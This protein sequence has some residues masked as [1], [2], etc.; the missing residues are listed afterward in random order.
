MPLYPYRG[1]APTVAADAWVAPTAS[2]VGDVEIASGASVWFNATIRG[3]TSYVRIGPGTSVQDNCVI[4]TDPGV[5]TIIGA[6]CTLG[7]GAIVHS[8]E[9]GDH[10]LIGTAAVLTGGNRVGRESL[11]GAGAVFPEGMEVG[12]RKVVVGVPARVARD[13]RP[14]D[15]RWTHQASDH[16]RDLS[17]WY[18]ENDPGGPRGQGQGPLGA[19]RQPPGT[20]R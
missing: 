2:V 1:K 14:Q 7:H 17:A 4:H 3:D 18:R 15:E 5:P 9:I 10:V 13:V 12:E 20:L 6:N 16:Y 11:V 8:S 19:E